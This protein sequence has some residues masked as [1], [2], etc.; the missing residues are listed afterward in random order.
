MK[1]VIDTDICEQKGLK[2]PELLAV[3]LVKSVANI[4]E[5]FNNLDERKV[6]VKDLFSNGYLVTQR[7]DDVC[8]DILCTSDKSLPKRDKLEDLALQ[9]MELF[10]KGKKDGTSVYWRGNKKDIL[11][12]LQKFFK[13]Y[14]DSYTEEQIIEA[15]K[16]YVQSFNGNYEYMRALKYFIW[17]DVMK[18]DEEGNRYVEKV[19]DLATLIENGDDD[20]IKNDWTSTLK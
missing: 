20:S 3:L 13:V 17:K 8:T 12:K 19:S 5:L 7:W 10:P 15:T 14:G 11:T 9:L 2:F 16:K 4:P 1:Y 18:L 6:L